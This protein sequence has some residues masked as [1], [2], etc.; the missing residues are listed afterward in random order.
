MLRSNTAYP[1]I[2]RSEGSKCFYSR[3][4]IPVRSHCLDHV[5]PRAKSG[6]N[7][8][9]NMVSCCA[10][11]NWQ[12]KDH[13]AADFL[14]ELYR[15]GRLSRKDLGGRLAALRAL[16]AGRLR[17]QVLSEKGAGIF[18]GAKAGG[19]LVSGYRVYQDLIR[20]DRRIQ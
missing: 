7:S 2:V 20:F 1:E 19:G 9:R 8:Y 3:R 14:R 12:K 5:V 16:A 17:P 10:E 15:E 4:R 18:A 11:C 6:L 13:A